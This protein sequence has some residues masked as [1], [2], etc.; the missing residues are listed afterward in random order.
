[1]KYQYLL[2]DQFGV[3]GFAKDKCGVNNGGQGGEPWYLI[4]NIYL[5]TGSKS[6]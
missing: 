6:Q 1:M 2:V 5:L 4:L 3:K